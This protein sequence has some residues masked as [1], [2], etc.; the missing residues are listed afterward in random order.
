V[1][2]EST[3]NY[4]NVSGLWAN[5][6]YEW[7]VMA[8]CSSGWTNWSPVG[9]FTTHQ[10]GYGGTNCTTPNHSHMSVSNTS[11]NYARTNCSVNGAEYHWKISQ[12][13]YLNW[14]DHSNSQ[15]HHGWT[16]LKPNTKYEWHV[17]VKCN[18][19]HW[20][21]WS[22]KGSFTTHGSGYGGSA[23][24]SP[25]GDQYTARQESYNLF[26]MYCYVSAPKYEWAV[27]RN[28]YDWVHHTTTSSN[29]GWGNLAPS[30]RY[31]Y[32]VRVT[33]NDGHH[34]N[35][36]SAKYF[37]T[38]TSG[39]SARSAPV[40]GDPVP[41][42]DAEAVRELAAEMTLFPNPAS[43]SVTVEGIVEGQRVMLF[44]TQGQPVY[45]RTIGSDRE[46][47]DLQ[48]L[49]SGIYQVVLQGDQGILAR[50]KLVVVQ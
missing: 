42:D 23:C 29:M 2:K 14:S 46:R 9:W 43:Q 16:N 32:K 24:H 21:S 4:H 11:H 17:K 25:H 27:Q 1:W 20:S 10:S 38:G 3:H 26:R 44:N 47:L 35:W 34:S 49:P 5:T 22:P 28:G 45:E 8:K 40:A 30:T 18:D 19:G 39:S 41:V 7:K 36:S 15:S 37:W 6:K 33:C 50:K 13:G 48:N 31:N 12:V